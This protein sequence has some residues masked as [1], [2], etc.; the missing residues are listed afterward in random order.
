[1]TPFGQGLSPL[2]LGA[3]AAVASAVVVLVY[4][5]VALQ[6]IHASVLDGPPATPPGIPAAHPTDAPAEGTLTVKESGYTPLQGREGTPMLSWGA[7]VVNTGTEL[8]ADGGV[9]V[10]VTAGGETEELTDQIPALEP[11][12][13]TFV[14]DTEY[15]PDGEVTSVQVVVTDM[16][17]SGTASPYGP[18]P[19][20]D[21]TITADDRGG[22]ELTFRIESPMASM[23]SF[24]A[25][26]ALF[27]DGD[28]RILGVD[29]YGLTNDVIPPGWSVRG[30]PVLEGMPPGTDRSTVEVTVAAN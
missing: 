18:M 26:R 5:P 29:R 11:G 20:T 2:R 12:A 27:R 13:E 30:F 4:T 15:I 21:V 14:G 1:M 16:R 25:Y 22:P 7:V 6:P 23:L 3:I 8:S 10:T 28:G 9:T 19:T 24:S 17:W